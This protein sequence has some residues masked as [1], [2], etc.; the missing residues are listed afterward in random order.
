MFSWRGAIHFTKGT[1]SSLAEVFLRL[2]FLCF[3]GSGL[4]IHLLSG[5]RL[6]RRQEPVE[7]TYLILELFTFKYQNKRNNI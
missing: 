2:G 6:N 1:R 3:S 5:L 4:Q 7:R